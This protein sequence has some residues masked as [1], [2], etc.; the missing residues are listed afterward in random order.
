MNS[1]DKQKLERMFNPRGIAIFGSFTGGSFAQMMLLSQIRYG[2]PGKLY[3]ISPRGGEISGVKIHKN[4]DEVEGPVDL[5]SL[6]IPAKGVPEVLRA[7]LK[8]GVAGAQIHS[9]GFRE[10]GEAEGL[11]LEKEIGRIAE[12]GLRIVGPNC[13][14]IHCPKGGLALL[15]GGFLSKEAGPVAMISQSGGGA[16]RFAYRADLANLGLSK[17]ISFGN[18][19][20]LDAVKLLEYLSH[21][22]ETGYVAAYL[23]GIGDGQ[24][25]LRVLREVTSKKPVVIWKGG[26]T[27][28]GS[29]ATQSHTGSLGG[30]AAIWNGA[31]SQAGAVMVQG[32]EEMADTLAALKY[33]R[34]R[35]NRIAVVGGGGAIG[36]FTSDLAHRYGLQIPTFTPETQAWLKQGFPTPGNSVLNPLD[37]GTP[38]FP[39]NILIPM[40]ERIMRTEAIELVVVVTLLHAVTRPL[41]AFVE[42]GNPTPPNAEYLESLLDAA[43]RLNGEMGKEIIIVLENW[44]EDVEMEALSNKMRLRFQDKGILVFTSSER[45]LM[46]IRNVSQIGTTT[47]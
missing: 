19:C 10:T 36:V 7:C 40:I 22:P 43:C 20:D 32:I 21:D 5:A 35:G 13:F 17:L 24:S 16:L 42:L 3:P 33:L 47:L 6:S 11:A 4:L 37:T 29:R 1:E 31:L 15:P 25:F 23:E 38:V 28:L 30:E 34:T 14:G 8:R 44:S 27:P 41:S 45:A 46:A 12:Q 9:S 26:L 18:G 2:Y 39:L